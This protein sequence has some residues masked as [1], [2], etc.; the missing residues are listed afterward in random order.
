MGVEKALYQNVLAANSS[1]EYDKVAEQ[2]QGGV[3]EATSEYIVFT[4]NFRF[5]TRNANFLIVQMIVTLRRRWMRESIMSMECPNGCL[6]DVTTCG[7]R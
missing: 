3:C 5:A 4:D 2:G 6:N 1:N 7:S